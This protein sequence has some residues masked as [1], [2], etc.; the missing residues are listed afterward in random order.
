MTCRDILSCSGEL[1]SH[2]DKDFILFIFVSY[3]ILHY[4][5]CG[6]RLYFITI[7]YH[8]LILFSY[9]LPRV[10]RSH[11][12]LVNLHVNKQAKRKLTWALKFLFCFVFLF[13]VVLGLCCSM[14][15]PQLLWKG[16]LFLSARASHCGG[17]SCC[18]AW[19]LGAHR[20]SNCRAWS[21][22]LCSTWNLLRP[23]LKPMSPELADGFLTTGT[24]K[25]MTK[26]I[27]MWKASWLNISDHSLCPIVWVS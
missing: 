14:G 10:T 17:I 13:F 1:E 9:I 11:V 26:L 25:E 2:L 6:F 22:L 12:G 21:Q 27:F 8:L 18:G 7:F 16:L 15:F 3:F 4:L 23:G 24:T 5:V 20:F 19:A